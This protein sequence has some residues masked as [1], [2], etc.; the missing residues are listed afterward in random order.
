MAGSAI[1]SPMI[2]RNL[3]TPQRIIR[4]I[5]G[6]VLFYGVLQRQEFDLAAATVL[7]CAVALTLN[8]IFSR[9]YLWSLLAFNSCRCAEANRKSIS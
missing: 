1:L 3:G 6:A 4:F 2:E 9:C 5:L 7:L 8:G